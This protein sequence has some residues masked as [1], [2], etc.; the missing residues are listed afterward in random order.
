MRGPRIV[1]IALVLAAAGYTATVVASHAYSRARVQYYD[2]G[3]GTKEK[4][5][6]NRGRCDQYDMYGQGPCNDSRTWGD[7]FSP[8]SVWYNFTN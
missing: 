1:G 7:F 2:A 5:G 3:I 4:I 6:L 8:A